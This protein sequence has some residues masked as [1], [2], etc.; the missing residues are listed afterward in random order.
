MRTN[1]LLAATLGI[2]LGCAALMNGSEAKSDGT[3]VGNAA[4]VYGAKSPDQI[5]FLSSPD[6]IL[7]VVSSGAPSAI[8]E[9][10]EHG[11]KVECLQCIPAVAPLLYDTHYAENREIAAWWL[12]RRVF[13]VFG[14]GE[15]YEQ[16]INT[17]KSDP[18]PQKRAYAASALGE[19]LVAPGIGATATAIQTDADPRVRAAAALALGRLND[20][21]GGALSKALGDGD[22]SVRLAALKSAGRINAFTDTQA[23]A[24]LAGDPDPKVRKRAMEVLDDMQAKDAVASVVAVAKNDSDP[25]VRVAACHALG[26]FHDASAKDVLNDLAAHDQNGFVKDMAAI[27]LR[28]L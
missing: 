10:L 22:S 7:S 9:A 18:D 2:F 21:G 27:A 24:R 8:W 3:Q 28:K 4:A 1:K 16:T 5:E 26:N 6:R 11:E 13:G 23:V 19:F 20:D 12:R 25:E 17:L 14:P 15:V